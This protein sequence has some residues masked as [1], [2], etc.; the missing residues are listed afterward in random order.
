MR[1]DLSS[2]VPISFYKGEG[3]IDAG[4]VMRI[5]SYRNLWV[6]ISGNLEVATVPFGKDGGMIRN[7]LRFQGKYVF[8][9]C[10]SPM[11]TSVPIDLSNELIP[12][13]EMDNFLGKS[14]RAM[15]AKVAMRYPCFQIT[16]FLSWKHSH[17]KYISRMPSRAASKGVMQFLCLETKG[18]KN[19]KINLFSRERHNGWMREGY[20]GGTLSEDDINEII[21]DDFENGRFRID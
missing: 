10:A 2:L 4:K 13:F 16:P 5:V 12:D 6:R 19:R 3:V 9:E 20:Q 18:D 17:M 14:N 7:M 8:I 15:F 11:G 1:V 21:N